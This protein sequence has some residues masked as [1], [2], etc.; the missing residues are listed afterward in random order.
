M[1]L[2]ENSVALVIGGGS[3]IGQ[4]IATNLAG[5]GAKVMVADI[6]QESADNVVQEIIKDGGE[7]TAVCGDV[8][9][10]AEAEKMVS[11]T[12]KAYGKIDIMVNCAIVLRD[13]SIRKM[14]EEE[15]D[16]VTRIGLKGTFL[17][18]QAAAEAMKENKYGRII[19]L[20]SVAYL[21]NYGQANYSATKGGVNSLTKTAAIEYAKFGVTVNVIA[22]GLIETPLTRSIPADVF[23]GIEAK[24]PAK[25]FGQPADISNLIAF[26]AGEDAGYITGQIIHVDG[27][28][29][30]GV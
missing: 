14:T 5:K 28:L 3:G 19:N 22:P 9:A 21:G 24:I 1:G 17:A 15:W 7:A 23:A 6:N 20:S 10:K 27:G 12:I 8:S 11:E 29:T 4:N 25:H 2:R 18:L 13:N 16:I 26:L 30:L